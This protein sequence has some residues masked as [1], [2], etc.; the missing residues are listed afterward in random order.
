MLMGE[1]IKKLRI[2][3]GLS[4]R[5]LADRVNVTPGCLWSI[6]K[7]N[8]KNPSTEML[9]ALAS[10][11]DTTFNYLYYGDKSINPDFL[12]NLPEGMEDFIKENKERYDIQNEDIADLVGMT[13]RGKQPITSEG[14]AYL[15]SSIR[16]IIT[17]GL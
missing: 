5:K 1:R 10:E 11:L 14:W 15:Y 9:L 13:Y 8:V 6:E 17:R 4:L 12:E 7:G 3:K 2:E 16:L